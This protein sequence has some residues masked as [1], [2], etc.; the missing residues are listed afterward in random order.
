MGITTGKRKNLLKLQ[1]ELQSTDLSFANSQ[2]DII[3]AT[4]CPVGNDHLPENWVYPWGDSSWSHWT[5][6]IIRNKDIYGLGVGV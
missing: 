4:S 1:E 3:L 2:K 5:R 6:L